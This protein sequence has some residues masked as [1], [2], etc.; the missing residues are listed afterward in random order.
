MVCEAQ[1]LYGPADCDA[2][3][4]GETKNRKNAGGAPSTGSP[5]SPKDAICYFPTAKGSSGMEHQE[6]EQAGMDRLKA[7]PQAAQGNRERTPIKCQ[8]AHLQQSFPL[9]RRRFPKT[10]VQ[11]CNQS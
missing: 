4:R 10:N 7:Q 1:S 2:R 11:S 3:G 9:V 8:V 6:F 5:S